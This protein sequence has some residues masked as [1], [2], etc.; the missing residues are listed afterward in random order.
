MIRSFARSLF[1]VA[2]LGWATA[3][4]AAPAG[5][6]TSWKAQVSRA[7]LEG[8]CNDAKTIALKANDIDTAAKAVM[9][10]KPGSKSSA[11]VAK[12]TSGAATKP[13][14]QAIKKKPIWMTYYYGNGSTFKYE[15]N[16]IFNNNGHYYV[17]SKLINDSDQSEELFYYAFKCKER[18]LNWAYELK[19][20]EK[21]SDLSD[22]FGYSEETSESKLRDTVCRLSPKGS[23]QVETQPIPRAQPRA[24]PTATTVKPTPDKPKPEPVVVVQGD[25]T[26]D[27]ATCQRYGYKPNQSDYAGCRLQLDQARQTATREQERYNAELARYQ[28]QVAELER[29]QRQDRAMRQFEGAMRLLA[30][31]GAGGSGS[32]NYQAPPPPQAPTTYQTIRL[33]NG[34]QVYCTVTGSYTSCN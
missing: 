2:L 7:I 16:S 30:G 26:P 11:I 13:N 1:V 20:K 9:L 18:N 8:R 5:V 17:Y 31:Q 3:A 10:C 24:T 14:N 23:Q 19:Y 27:D 25:G 33:P 28:Q 15:K 21:V 34:S 4:L 6:N 32:P 12:K 22:R 29:Q